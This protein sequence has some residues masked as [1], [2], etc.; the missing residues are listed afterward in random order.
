MTSKTFTVPSISCGHC[1]HT[2]KMEVGDLDGVKTVTA[3]EKTKEVTVEWEA[4][5]T[6]EGIEALLKEIDFPPA[7]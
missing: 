4:P 7:S 1:T 5:Q 3:D 2:I 6:W